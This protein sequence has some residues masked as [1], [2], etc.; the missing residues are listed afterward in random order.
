MS[1]GLTGF[2]LLTLELKCHLQIWR[3]FFLHSVSE[4]FNWIASYLDWLS[5][6]YVDH[7]AFP[8]SV[9]QREGRRP[10]LAFP[11]L[12]WHWTPAASK[13]LL[14]LAKLQRSAL[15]KRNRPATQ[16]GSLTFLSNPK[17]FC[18]MLTLSMPFYKNSVDF[19][20]VNF[21][22]F[23]GNIK[24]NNRCLP[25]WNIPA[26]SDLAVPETHRPQLS[27]SSPCM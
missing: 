20:A 13:I 1:W 3:I 26:F 5:C 21:H 7:W 6:L 27:F 14:H 11:C 23:F 10:V 25:K 2:L 16:W 19:D 17:R 12:S 24:Q 9:S 22:S 18:K 15:G 4:I 8:P